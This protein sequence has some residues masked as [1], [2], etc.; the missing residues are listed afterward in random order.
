MSTKVPT[1][2]QISKDV[3]DYLDPVDAK[4]T[5]KR[6][7]E[8]LSKFSDLLDSLS[9]I[10]DK[11][12]A[13]WKEIYENAITDR[14]NAYMLY[15]TLYVQIMGKDE[16]THSILGQ[17]INKYLE[18]M[19]KSNDQLIKLAELIADAESTKDLTSDDMFNMIK[20]K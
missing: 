7:D 8:K 15:C 19:S 14:D 2:E 1:Q 16:T 12:K 5:Y 6:R 17:I 11:K 9:S 20:D 4:A 18:R 13:L 10:E 3:N